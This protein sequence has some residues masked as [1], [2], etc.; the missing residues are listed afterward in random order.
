[1][2]TPTLPRQWALLLE[3]WELTIRA[4]G[5][6]PKTLRTYQAGLASLTGWLAEH[7]PD[8]APAEL[9]RAQVR[10]WI[11]HVRERNGASTAATYF[12][13]VRHFTRYLVAEEEATKDATAGVRA[14]IPAAPSTAVL[15]PEDLKRLLAGCDR[16]TLV[17]CR[18]AAIIL[19]LADG[20]LRLAE[21]VGLHLHDVDQSSRIL[22]VLGK[23]TQRRG[24]RPRAVPYGIR[25][26]QALNR[27]LRV[28][29][30]HPFH[31]SAALWLATG[32][33]TTV[34]GDAVRRMLARRGERAGI[35][36]LHPHALR[37]TWASAFRA[38]GGS[39]G[40][41]MALGG[42]RNRAMLDRYGAAAAADRAA[43]SYRRLSLGDRL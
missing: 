32:E 16:K 17:G 36:G 3:G 39:E 40:D 5:Y 35:K 33:R 20:G 22:Y 24:P 9:D 29:E 26:A 11:A 21:L 34:S 28:R 31:T 13:G 38:A 27:Y 23:G 7:H 43:D 18:D 14:P 30:R 19:V 6:S 42:W 15:Q 25:T 2:A 1:M 8:L 10:G 12:A 37:H 41:L 4:D